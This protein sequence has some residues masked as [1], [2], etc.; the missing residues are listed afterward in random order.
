MPGRP[1]GSSVAIAASALTHV[2]DADTCRDARRHD[3]RPVVQ[4][5]EAGGLERVENVDGL[6][7]AGDCAT[8]RVGAGVVVTRGFPRRAARTRR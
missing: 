2:V 3:P 1:K 4:P 5:R 6:D 8:R 7:L